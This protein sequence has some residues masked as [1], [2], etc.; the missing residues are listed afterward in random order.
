MKR[1][2]VFDTN[3]NFSAGHSFKDNVK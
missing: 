1:N 3:D 2:N